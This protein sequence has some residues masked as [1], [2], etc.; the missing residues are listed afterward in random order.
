MRLMAKSRVTSAASGRL[1]FAS[2]RYLLRRRFVRWHTIQQ[3]QAVSCSVRCI[4]R[5]WHFCIMQFY[6]PC[7]TQNEENLLY[8]GGKY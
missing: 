6:V 2:E 1:A 4:A 8:N 3:D 5:L 7:L